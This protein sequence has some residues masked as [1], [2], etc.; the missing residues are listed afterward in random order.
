MGTYLDEILDFHRG[1]S[2]DD[3]RSLDALVEGTTELEATRGFKKSLLD[4]PNKEVA[5]IAEI[6]RRSPSLGALLESLT[7]SELGREYEQGGA[8]ALS[9]LTDE[10]HFDGS[11]SDLKEA[12]EVT[13]IPVLRKDFTVDLRDICDARIMGADAVLLIAVSYTHLTLPTKA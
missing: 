9:V 12:R 3:N 6:K 4:T 1:R 8:S 7:P 2:Q 10:K 5:V 13:S 11:S